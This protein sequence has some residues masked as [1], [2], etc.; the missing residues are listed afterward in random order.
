M[1]RIERN[2]EIAAVTLIFPHF[3]TNSRWY[4]LRPRLA[5]AWVE[6]KFLTVECYI[7]ASNHMKEIEGAPFF[8]LKPSLKLAN[9]QTTEVAK[10][11]RA[12]DRTWNN[13]KL[14]LSLILLL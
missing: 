9:D 4:R 8:L 14:S 12:P 2:G 7:I 1:E 11:S 13:I 6:G 10:V 3:P 5:N